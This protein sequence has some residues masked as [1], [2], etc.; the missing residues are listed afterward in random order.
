MYLTTTLSVAMVLFLIGMECVLLLS[1]KQLISQVKESAVVEVV[2]KQN[3]DSVSISRMDKLLTNAPYCLNHHYISADEALQ[4]HIRNL[5]EDPAKFLGYNPLLASYEFH[6][7]ENY[8]NPDSLVVIEKRLS[9]LPYVEQVVYQENLFSILNRHVREFS[10][11][12]LAIAGLLLLISL[13]LIGNTIRLQIYSQRFLINTMTLVGAKAS[14]IKAP[15]V[16]RSMGIGFSAGI[17]ALSGLAGAM[18]YV[19]YKLG[20]LLFPLTWQNIAFVCGIVLL[21]GLMITLFASLFAT[22]RYIRMRTD[23]MY[24]I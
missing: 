11:W 15:I 10:W 8:A 9:S 19:N 17:L 20:V 7:R 22:G 13:V 18:W 12:L 23:V 14:M 4:E 1:T 16:R 6:L 5:G 2:L 24:E 3:A 21:T